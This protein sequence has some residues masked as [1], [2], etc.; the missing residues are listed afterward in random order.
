MPLRHNH[1]LV[2]KIFETFFASSSNL[3]AFMIVEHASC[4]GDKSLIMNQGKE[5]Q[6]INLYN[7][8]LYYFC[9]LYLPTYKKLSVN[10]FVM[11]TL[12]V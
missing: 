7:Y 12:V 10:I 4:L 5:E 6:K 3:D 8:Q 2:E 1:G 9:H 11:S